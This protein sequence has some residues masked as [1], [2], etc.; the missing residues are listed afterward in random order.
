MR[1]DKTQVSSM[2]EVEGRQLIRQLGFYRDGTCCGG[3]SCH[4]GVESQIQ[5]KV[6]Q[7]ILRVAPDGLNRSE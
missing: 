4:G 5:F 3:R 7:S 6:G 2:I 1:D